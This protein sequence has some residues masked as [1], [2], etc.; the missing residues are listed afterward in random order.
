MQRELLRLSPAAQV[1]MADE[2]YDIADAEHF[3]MQWRMDA[4]GQFPEHLPASGETVMEVGCGAGA[5]LEAL[6]ER[7]GYVADGSDLN[8]FALAKAKPGAGTLMVY[9]VLSCQEELREK[10]A[11]VFLMDVIEHIEDDVDFVQ[12]AAHLVRPDGMVVVNVPCSNHL[13]SKYDEVAGHVRRYSK[14]QLRKTFEAA[15]LETVHLAYWGFS[16]LPVLLARNLLC[17]FTSREKVIE[18][19]FAP[20]GPLA[21]GFLHTLRKLEVALLKR[22]PFGTSLLGF[23]RKF[24]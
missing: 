22:P 3:W 23:A 19:G 10:Y 21:H 14:A 20:P 4:M 15:G 16:L 7:F 17:K 5:V 24:G 13:Y 18:R 9:D 11:A 2:W 1:A 12:A 6:E 8:L